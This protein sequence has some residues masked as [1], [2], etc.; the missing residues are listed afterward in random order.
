MVLHHMKAM[1]ITMMALLL[2]VGLRMAIGSLVLL[3]MTAGVVGVI[4][5]NVF[6]GEPLLYEDSHQIVYIL[7]LAASIGLVG[8]VMSVVM[9]FALRPP[10][11]E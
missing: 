7:A 3:T 2:A 4:V 6:D 11:P 5:K 10:V 1:S 8:F 9:G